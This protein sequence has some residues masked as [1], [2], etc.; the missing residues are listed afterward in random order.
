MTKL[1]WI[2]GTIT[3]SFELENF[4]LKF[5][6]SWLHSLYYICFDLV[7]YSDRCYFFLFCWRLKFEIP[8]P[9]QYN[10]QRQEVIFNRLMEHNSSAGSSSQCC[11][12]I[13]KALNAPI[14]IKLDD[15]EIVHVYEF[16]FS[17]TRLSIYM[18][19]I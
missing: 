2:K 1:S 3:F 8:K 19:F 9:M 10:Q 12:D 5:Y 4:V 18:W 15:M 6:F 13:A 14:H 17:G 11:I 7:L 16:E